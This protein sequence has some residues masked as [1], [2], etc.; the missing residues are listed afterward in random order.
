MIHPCCWH[1]C[2]MPG[3]IRKEIRTSPDKSKLAAGDTLESFQT[4][5]THRTAFRWRRRPAVA[6]LS[7]CRVMLEGGEF[8]S[9]KSIVSHTATIEASAYSAGY[10]ELRLIAI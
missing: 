1:R 7:S 2:N 10:R 6:N 3:T 8:L 9:S 4:K 5:D